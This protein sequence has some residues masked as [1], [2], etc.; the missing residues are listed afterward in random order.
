MKTMDA[1]PTLALFVKLLETEV[2]CGAIW[3]LVPVLAAYLSAH[4]VLSPFHS[5][6]ETSSISTGSTPFPW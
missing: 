2:L 4:L 5:V 3:W 1:S 6:T